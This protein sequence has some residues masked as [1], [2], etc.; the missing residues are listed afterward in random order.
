MAEPVDWPALM[1]LGLGV[2]RLPP[3]AFWSMTPGELRRALEGAGIVPAGGQVMDRG[4]LAELM[5]AFPDG[6]AEARPRTGAP[7]P[8]GAGGGGEHPPPPP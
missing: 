7:P 3:D 2:L 8:E 4:R 5:A 1:R 6:G